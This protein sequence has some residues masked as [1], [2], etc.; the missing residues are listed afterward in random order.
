[1][2]QNG[3]RTGVKLSFGTA[4]AFMSYEYANDACYV[5]PY[6]PKVITTITD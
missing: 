5:A 1:M 2:I 4:T 3:I 6:Y